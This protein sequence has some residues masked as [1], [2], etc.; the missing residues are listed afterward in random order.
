MEGVVMSPMVREQAGFSGGGPRVSLHV[1]VLNTQK[2]V[3]AAVGSILGQTF[4]DFDLVLWDEGGTLQVD[5]YALNDTDATVTLYGGQLN[6]SSSG[7]LDSGGTFSSYGGAANNDGLIEL[8]SSDLG[9][10]GAI[11]NGG[12]NT[13]T[14]VFEGDVDLTGMTLSGGTYEIF[15]SAT[16]NG[17]LSIASGTVVTNYGTFNQN[18]PDGTANDSIENQGEMVAGDLHETQWH[19]TDYETNFSPAFSLVGDLYNSNGSTFNPRLALDEWSQNTSAVWHTSSDNPF[20]LSYDGSGTI[21]FTT[22]NQTLSE[23]VSWSESGLADVLYFEAS[24]NGSNFANTSVAFSN[25]AMSFNTT[26]FNSATAQPFGA[27]AQA[28][29][30]PNGMVNALQVRRVGLANHPWQVRGFIDPDHTTSTLNR[31]WKFRIRGGMTPVVAASNVKTP[32]AIKS[33]NKT[34]V[35]SGVTINAAAGTT[36][37]LRIVDADTG[38]GEITP[39][40]AFEVKDSNIIAKDNIKMT[41]TAQNK[42]TWARIPIP[43]GT[44]SGTN[45]TV[46]FKASS[47]QDEIFTVIIHV[48]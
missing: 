25:L 29:G 22:D 8:K 3:E 16:N 1:T 46:S 20:T 48:P 38:N 11:N 23:T 39:G 26:E 24:T 37:K 30:N 4:R 9:V 28:G 18:D 33:D 42:G 14:M 15:G 36:L 31:G 12:S 40:I 5:G 21:S 43:A 45:I 13:G 10:I 44:T 47:D 34:Y 7:D 19:S 35:A 32:Q 27:I 6:V 17:G 2:Y 41:A